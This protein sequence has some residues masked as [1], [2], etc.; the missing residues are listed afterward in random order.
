ML[1]LRCGASALAGTIQMSREDIIARLV[2]VRQPVYSDVSPSAV[3]SAILDALI[4]LLRAKE[5]TVRD[6]LG[7]A[8][9]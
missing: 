3:E 9:K 8:W 7:L 5:T 6:E 2:A 4:E 1:V